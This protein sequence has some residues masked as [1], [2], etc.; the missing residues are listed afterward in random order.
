MAGL[1]YA[2][3]FTIKTIYN[4]KRLSEIK[5]DFIGNMTHELKTPISTISLACEALSD[6]EI[7]S[8]EG[9]KA[10][11]V[12]MINEENKRLG[13]LV[14]NVLQTAIIDRG[15]LKLKEEPLGVHEI[16]RNATNNIKIQIESKN[17]EMVLV[18]VVHKVITSTK[19]LCGPQC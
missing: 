3:Y 14:E 19:N 12:R 6:R 9:Q 13:V 5:N 18:V 4:Q 1:G 16:I 2:F 17:G 10:N 7:E 11:F 15:K 8:T